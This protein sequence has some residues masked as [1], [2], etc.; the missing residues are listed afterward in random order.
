VRNRLA[1]G[2]LMASLLV[3]GPPAAARAQVAALGPVPDTSCAV[4]PADNI[5]NTRVDALPLHPKSAVWLASMQA[6]STNLHPDFGPPS[7][8]MP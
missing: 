2:C 6:G 4:F 5:W 7:Y 1:F 8:G 3:T